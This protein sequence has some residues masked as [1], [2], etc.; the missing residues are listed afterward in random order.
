M[1][2]PAGKNGQ[3]KQYHNFDMSI[4]KHG[5]QGDTFNKLIL[6]SGA[7]Y[8]DFTDFDNPGTLLGATRG[9]AVFKKKPV[10]KDLAYDGIAGQVKGQKHLID[11]KVTLEVNLITWDTDNLLKVLPSSE[12]NDSSIAGYDEITDTEWDADA[13]YTLTNIAIIAQLSGSDDPIAIILDNPIC[14]NDLTINFRDKSEA[15]GK[16]IFSAFYDESDGFDTPPWRILWPQSA[17]YFMTVAGY[18]VTLTTKAAYSADG[19]N[20]TAATLPDSQRWRAVAYGNGMYVAIA[21]GTDVA[22]YSTDGINWTQTTMPSSKNWAAV[23]YGNGRFVAT[24]VDSFNTYAAYSTDGINWTASTLAVS[25]EWTC[26]AYGNGYFVIA[27]IINTQYSTDGITWTQGGSFSLSSVSPRIAYGNGTFVVVG[28]ADRAYYSTDNG[29]NWTQ[30]ALPV[31]SSYWQ[32]VAYGNGRFVTMVSYGTTTAYS[33]DGITWVSGGSL[34]S[35]AAWW[36]I[37]F[38]IDKFVVVSLGSNAAAYS[39]DGGATWTATTLTSSSDWG[40]V[41]Y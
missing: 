9:G 4:R 28:S 11:S 21:Y 39:T 35:S 15:G 40:D 32:K 16:F 27:D 36:G 29:I 37:A 26:I 1:P 20:F 13:V 12:S 31:S 19:I 30:V 24:C 3:K 25:G 17:H 10:Y 7:I 34:P 22:A 5:I 8:T 41:T 23:A 6:D 2:G 38:G 14:E 18:A 33:T